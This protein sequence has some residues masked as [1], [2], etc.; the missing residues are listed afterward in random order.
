MKKMMAA[1]CA[2]MMSLSVAQAK[3]PNVVERGIYSGGGL[4]IGWILLSVNV[5]L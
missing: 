1:V 5:C 4:S 3:H 2:A